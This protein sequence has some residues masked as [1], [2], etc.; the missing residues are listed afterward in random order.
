M[1]TPWEPLSKLVGDPW[2][3][4]VAT[5]GNQGG[6]PWEPGFCFFGLNLSPFQLRKSRLGGSG[7]PS[8]DAFGVVP[9]SVNRQ[10]GDF[11]LPSTPRHPGEANTMKP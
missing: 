7:K 9:S 5:R 3:P 1:A 6:D 4:G 8:A 11:P 2:E 10:C